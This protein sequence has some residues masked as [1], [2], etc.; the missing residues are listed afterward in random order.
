MEPEEAGTFAQA[1]ESTLKG[2][3]IKKAK[4]RGLQSSDGTPSVFAGFGG[5]KAPPATGAAANF[6]FLS[7]PLN[8]SAA[9]AGFNF[10]SAGTGSFTF[11]KATNAGGTTEPAGFSG[12][13]KVMSNGNENK[14]E[15]E[16]KKEQSGATATTDS[17]TNKNSPFVFGKASSSNGTSTSLFGSSE[18]P[19]NSAS[20]FGGAANSIP[21]AVKSGPKEGLFGVSGQIKQ[22]LKDS[23]E[24][25]EKTGDVKD[26]NTSNT[27]TP[28]NQ[29]AAFKGNAGDKWTCSTCMVSNDADK[30]ACGCC[31][32]LKP[33][34]VVKRKWTCDTCM[35]SNDADKDACVCCEA[36]KPGSI[37]KKNEVA[38]S[39][40]AFGSIGSGGFKFGA[41]SEATSTAATSGFKF[42]TAS[43]NTNQPQ[44]ETG[45]KFGTDS[46][47]STN[48]VSAPFKFGNTSTAE[49]TS[50]ENTT[51]TVGTPLQQLGTT[52]TSD[53]EI[54]KIASNSQDFLSHLAALNKQFLAWIQQHVEKNPYVLLAPCLKDYEKHLNELTKEHNK[55]D[56]KTDDNK[57]TKEGAT[58]GTFTSV[59]A[60]VPAN[61]GLLAGV[62]GPSSSTSSAKPFSFGA[63]E[64]A[65]G[66]T[67][68]SGFAF[69][70]STPAN[71]TFAA[72]T[73][74]STFGSGSMFG[75]AA[76][77][78]M[79]AKKDESDNAAA[80]DGADDNDE[81]QPPKVEINQVVE[82][83]SIH[84]VRCKLYYKK[85]KEFAE[86]GLGMLY[87]K[88]VDSE[89]GT[90]NKT[91]L[92]VRAETNLG[93]ILLNI[94]LNKQMNLT[95]RNNCVQFV[96]IPNPEIPGIKAGTPVTMLVKVKN[97]DL[98]SILEDEIK[99]EIENM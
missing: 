20:I 82:Q 63:S 56:A 2:R 38:T 50:K 52:C 61:K 31:E 48:S 34:G 88:R 77:A 99:K 75:Q 60:K 92:L 78:A 54:K 81:D 84:S 74:G 6:D 65:S 43:A 30:A 62:F 80:A 32:T 9:S 25:K 28:L 73:T 16:S 22:N 17:S 44:G 18:K 27:L 76:A 7:K 40:T 36:A 1:D 37:P 5:F 8:G 59:E 24:G 14:S 12:V 49:S 95:K 39:N 15:N 72:S 64:T 87:L 19:D 11:G 58:L 96:C 13:P 3:V 68:A 26:Q 97:A 85:G 47:K 70:S 51:E 4:R 23:T 71:F 94:L 86:K 98:A 66:N 53:D 93:N 57:A 46:V 35:V 42:G 67:A 29:L 21:F 69:G 10:P 79:Q 90:S 91:Q 89:E 83:D 55:S 41:A 45:F 33:G